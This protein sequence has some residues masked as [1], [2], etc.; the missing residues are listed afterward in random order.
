MKLTSVEIH[1]DGSSNVLVLS[2]RDPQAL[3]PFNAESI[4]GLDPEAIVA[5]FY[6]GSGSSKFFDMA[7]LKRQIVM[8]VKLNPNFTNNETFSSLRDLIYKTIA[9]SRTGKIQLQFKN[10][11]TVVAVSSAFVS[12]VEAPQFDKKQAVKITMDCEKGML[13][14]PTATAVPVGGFNPAGLVI[15]DSASTAHH[16]FAFDMAI[17][18]NTPS[19]VI[20][21]P[22]D[23]SWS[24]T[25]TPVGGFLI[26]DV[27]HFSSMF[28][29]KYIN[30]TR[31]GVTIELAEV[32]A[33]GS[34]WPILFPGDNHFQFSN[35]TNLAL[36]AISYYATFWGV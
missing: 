12:K 14:A 23:A 25:V 34:I 20:S 11:T 36:S 29:N 24:F 19:I 3:N 5:K 33:L 27:L 6:G 10:G 35:P 4:T 13:E 28:G 16:G 15:T 21:D 8:T 18:V 22:T 1:P 7:V 26:G 9:S 2:F 30:L 31:G 32:V 17:N